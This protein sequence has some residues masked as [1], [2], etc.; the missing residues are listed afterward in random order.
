MDSELVPAYFL[1]KLRSEDRYHY[2][3]C[4]MIAS[5]NYQLD[6]TPTAEGEGQAPLLTR[7]A[8]EQLLGNCK[9]QHRQLAIEDVCILP[10]PGG[11]NE[12]WT[13]RT[14]RMQSGRDQSGRTPD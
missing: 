9:D 6:G 11:A 4:E 14:A 13:L 7:D 10:E 5:C 12:S 8:L 3:F 2:L 1:V